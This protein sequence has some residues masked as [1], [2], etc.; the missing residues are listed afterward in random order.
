MTKLA[1]PPDPLEREPARSRQLETLGAFAAGIAH[2]FNNLLTAI[3][4]SADLALARD[5]LD[6]ATRE[7]VDEIRRSAE[8]GSALIGRL[9]A[10]DAPQNPEP[11]AIAI[12][13][14]LEGV[15]RLLR[16]LLGRRIVLDLDPGAPGCAVRMDPMQLDRVLIN[17][18]ANAR[19]AMPRGG[20][21][22]LRSFPETLVE[23]RSAVLE[24]MPPGRYV[25]IEVV[26]AGHGIPPEM[27]PRI[28][29][30]FFTT[31]R[32]RGGTGLGL[33]SAIG[34]ARQS[35]GFMTVDSVP[36]QGSRFMLHLP[37][38][39]DF[40]SQPP[41][42][43][44]EGRTVLLVDDDEGVRRIAHRG[45]R[46][47]GWR[48]LAAGS[49]EAALAMLDASGAAP[50]LLV[51]DFSLPEMDGQALISAVLRRYPGVPAVLVSG[52]DG[53]ALRDACAGLGAGFL[54]KPY[55]LAA[56]LDAAGRAVCGAPA[57]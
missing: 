8:R 43:A 37:R 12:D 9:L 31:K 3:L 22:T 20:R 15:A 46:Q 17:L 47:R 23:P 54:A 21:L 41:L 55:T 35:G 1:D 57:S 11:P 4:A 52:Y 13:E 7:D 26:D 34:I 29:D 56:L 5:G 40:A 32:A 6:P 33:A 45:L 2:D 51:A 42:V 49:A 10:S 28:F 50:A 25:T 44:G 38:H 36:G 27:L 18:A 24:T 30:P 19:D 16:R 48:V 39:D 14:A 53:A